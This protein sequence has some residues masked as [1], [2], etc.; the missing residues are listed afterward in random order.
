MTHDTEEKHHIERKTIELVEEG[1]ETKLLR[2]ELKTK[3]Q[4]LRFGT[5]QPGN[6]NFQIGSLQLI[7]ILLQ[8]IIILVIAVIEYLKKTDDMCFNTKQVTFT[9]NIITMCTSSTICLVLLFHNYLIL[10]HWKEVI[11]NEFWIGFLKAVL[12]SFF[13]SPTILYFYIINFYEGGSNSYQTVI[14]ASQFIGGLICFSEWNFMLSIAFWISFAISFFMHVQEWYY[15]LIG[16][17]CVLGIGL[18]IG[19]EVGNYYVF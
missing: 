7:I 8:L 12:F 18:G 1:D 6:G 3:P 14:V 5:I 4:I 11:K 10:V 19:Q 2:S 13:L 17:I 15:I 9:Y 16:T